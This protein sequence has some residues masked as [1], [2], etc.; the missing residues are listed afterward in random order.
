MTYAEA[1][2]LIIRAI[3]Y[4]LVNKRRDRSIILMTQIEDLI[5]TMT[6]DL[7]VV[8][9]EEELHQLKVRIKDEIIVYVAQKRI[10]DEVQQTSQSEV[11]VKSII[12]RSSRITSRTF[13]SNSV[14][15]HRRI[16][17]ESTHMKTSDSYIFR[18]DISQSTKQVSSDSEL[19]NMTEKDL[20]QL[21]KKVE[22]R[23][24]NR[25]TCSND[26]KMRWKREMNN[27][28]TQILNRII[29]LLIRC[30]TFKKVCHTHI[31]A[32]ASRF[33]LIIN[34]SNDILRQKLNYLYQHRDSIE[35][36]KINQRIYF[37][38][39]RNNRLIRLT[40]RLEFYRFFHST[41]LE[42]HSDW[43]AIIASDLSSRVHERWLTTENIFL[44]KMFSWWFS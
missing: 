22:N 10:L 28:R 18:Q 3:V 32:L 17:S 25:C 20:M 21:K 31:R 40:D 36:V 38:F 34:H 33:D 29:A 15:A 9:S 37:W 19:S 42:Y 1:R 11:A 24:T 13:I 6:S 12:S 2:K 27:T 35:D 5:K 30:K 44:N 16:V 23:I 14:T 41:L 7:S 8:S 43:Q 4:R 39:K 26:V